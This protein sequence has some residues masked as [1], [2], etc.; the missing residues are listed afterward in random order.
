MRKI[1]VKEIILFMA[2]AAAVVFSPLY[3]LNA[4]ETAGIQTEQQQPP[5]PKTSSSAP[6]WESFNQLMNGLEEASETLTLPSDGL[7]KKLSLSETHL[8]EL[9]S[10]LDSYE[11]SAAMRPFLA[12]RRRRHGRVFGRR[13]C[14][15]VTGLR[16]GGRYRKVGSGKLSYYRDIS[17][18]CGELSNPDNSPPSF[19]TTNHALRY[20][21][22]NTPNFLFAVLA[23]VRVC[24]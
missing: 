8:K 13:L 19:L 7:L 15:R 1:Y 6:L 21:K 4:Q 17:Q 16:D 10:L 23:F 14:R 2:A 3:P 11:S 24:L 18:K 9:N 5:Q 12:A 20:A 22:Y